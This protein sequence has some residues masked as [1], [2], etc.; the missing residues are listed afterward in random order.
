M[1]VKSKYS[2]TKHHLNVQQEDHT[3]VMY[4]LAA[5]T[6]SRL[7]ALEAISIFLQRAELPIIAAAFLNSRHVSSSLT[8]V[9]TIKP[10]GTSVSSQISENGVPCKWRKICLAD[11]FYSRKSITELIRSIV[12][13]RRKPLP[14]RKPLER[15]QTW[16][17][18]GHIPRDLL[19]VLSALEALPALW[20]YC[21][22]WNKSIRS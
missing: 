4:K 10:S 14:I 21:T 8:M 12:F 7:I 13:Y 19:A 2:H 16:G 6:M 18:L 17:F 3:P 15:D 1:L 22:I 9:L 5:K 11:Q 20:L